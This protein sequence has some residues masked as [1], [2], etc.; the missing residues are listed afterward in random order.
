VR[1]RILLG[2][3]R[4]PLEIAEPHRPTR[5][6][7][8]RFTPLQFARRLADQPSIGDQQQQQPDREQRN[9]PKEKATEPFHRSIP[10]KSRPFAID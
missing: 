10:E 3:D 5:I 2:S 7:N 8:R 9:A 1:R 6:P 4:F